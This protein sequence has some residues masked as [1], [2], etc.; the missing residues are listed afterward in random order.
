MEELV[1]RD[2]LITTSLAQVGGHKGEQ[3][4][5]GCSS[6]SCLGG[7]YVVACNLQMRRS[8]HGITCAM[9]LCVQ[10]AS[11][12]SQPREVVLPEEEVR[13]QRLLGVWWDSL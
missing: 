6:P 5:G 12:Q 8:Y 9:L 10:A 4:T 3:D 7:F 13:D 2:M 11:V 1:A